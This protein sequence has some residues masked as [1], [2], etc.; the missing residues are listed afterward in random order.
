MIF[1]LFEWTLPGTVIY[2]NDPGAN[3]GGP[4]VKAGGQRIGCMGMR[5]LRSV[6]MRVPDRH[7]ARRRILVDAWNSWTAAGRPTDRRPPPTD[8]PRPK[9]TSAT[10]GVAG[11]LTIRLGEG[12][13]C[14]I[15]SVTITVTEE[16]SETP[17][18]TAELTSLRRVW[19]GTLSGLTVG[20]G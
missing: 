9:R 5:H 4:R 13:P 10:C 6:R 2:L 17:V 12:R 20:N 19:T 1:P 3:P 8:A 14:D 16:S 18:A 11:P 15:D 7:A